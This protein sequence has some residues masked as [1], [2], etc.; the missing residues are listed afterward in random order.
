[1][2][3]WYNDKRIK[4]QRE[5]GLDTDGKIWP[6]TRKALESK[7]PLVSSPKQE[8]KSPPKQESKT[9]KQILDDMNQMTN[10]VQQQNKPEPQIQQQK[11]YQNPNINVAPWFTHWDLSA[12][13]WWK[14]NIW[15]NAKV[16]NVT[17]NWWTVNIWGI[18][19][20]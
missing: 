14:I 13:N 16:G 10:N 7:V 17:A 12:T 20:L 2:K 19:H 3:N 11:N 8:D 1:M 6:L 4:F 15:P 5:N 18:C 9:N